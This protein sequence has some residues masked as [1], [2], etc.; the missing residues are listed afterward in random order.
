[1]DLAD[2]GLELLGLLGGLGRIGAELAAEELQDVA[3][4][5]GRFTQVVERLVRRYLEQRD[6]GERF[7]QWVER[8]EETDLK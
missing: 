1:M 3:Q 5:L 7:P 2:D 8:A 4:A 6:E